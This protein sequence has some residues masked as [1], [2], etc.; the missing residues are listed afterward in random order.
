MIGIVLGTVGCA[1]RLDRPV[2]FAARPAPATTTLADDRALASAGYVCLGPIEVSVD[3]EHCRAG[4]C[5]PIKDPESSGLLLLKEAARRGGDIVRV[6][7]VDA[8][9]VVPWTS[10]TRSIALSSGTVWRREPTLV[11]NMQL[12][13]AVAAGDVAQVRALLLRGTS[14]NVFLHQA[15]LELAAR[16][17]HTQILAALLGAGAQA[18]REAALLAAVD[19]GDVPAAQLLLNAG[20]SPDAMRAVTGDRPL[21]V[22]AYRRGSGAMIKLLLQ[23]GAEVD[24]RNTT[25]QTALQ[26]AVVSCDVEAATILLAAGADATAI[27]DDETT[28]ALAQQRCPADLAAIERQSRQ[29]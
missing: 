22:A 20:V 5:Q 2:H 17:G 28:R 10:G 14:P 9:A 18:G 29:P 24:G 13:Q 15:P 26:F 27:R 23:A 11:P 25:L 6:A 19:R 7:K 8:A 12:E 4:V 21:H 16:K 3:K 1:G